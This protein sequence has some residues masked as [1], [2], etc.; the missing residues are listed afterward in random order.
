MLVT[1]DGTTRAAKRY[2]EKELGPNNPVEIGE[3]G[4]V[5][6]DVKLPAAARRVHRNVQVCFQL[7]VQQS[8]RTVN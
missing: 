4:I 7:D 5:K 6:V 2:G 3:P 8:C 1:V